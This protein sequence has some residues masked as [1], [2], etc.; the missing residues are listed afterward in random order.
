MTV[1]GRE[2]RDINMGQ[3]VEAIRQFFQEDN[4]SFTESQVDTGLSLR[5][6]GRNGQWNCYARV[7]EEDGQFAFYSYAP[8]DI[9]EAKYPVTTEYITRANFGLHIGD[10]EFNFITGTVQFKTSIDVKGQ[11]SGLTSTL[12]RHLVYTN[13]VT[14]DKYLPGLELVVMGKATPAQAIARTEADE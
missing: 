4:W 13:V 9:P 7:R 12:I 14:M 10:F 6:G 11:E 3:L 1:S 5:F 2:K 8:V